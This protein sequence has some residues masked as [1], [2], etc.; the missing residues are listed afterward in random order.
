MKLL[1]DWNY[2]QGLI[3]ELVVGLYEVHVRAGFL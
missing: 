3:L 2:A 1:Y